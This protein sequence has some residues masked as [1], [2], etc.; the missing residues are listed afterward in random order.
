MQT[1]MPAQGLKKGGRPV[2]RRYA[3][4]GHD[5]AV[6]ALV[7]RVPERD[8]RPLPLGGLAVLANLVV[9]RQVAGEDAGAEDQQHRK[10]EHHVDAAPLRT[11]QAAAT[12]RRRSRSGRRNWP[13]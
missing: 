4:L 13:V 5:L 7:D 3:L 11:V 6:R 1:K 12:A 2:W 8:V 10:G 9:A